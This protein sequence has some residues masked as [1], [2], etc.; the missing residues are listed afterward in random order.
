MLLLDQ[1]AFTCLTETHHPFNFAE[2]P[3]LQ[4]I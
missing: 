3:A 4:A 1:Y 2:S